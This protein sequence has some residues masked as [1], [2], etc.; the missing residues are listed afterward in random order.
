MENLAKDSGR[1]V[2]SDMNEMYKCLLMDFLNFDCSSRGTNGESHGLFS[3][4][5]SEPFARHFWPC[6][7]SSCWGTFLAIIQF[8]GY[9]RKKGKSLSCVRL[10]GLMDC[11]LPGSSIHG[12]SQAR[13]LEWGAIAISNINNQERGKKESPKP[14]W[15]HWWILLSTVKRTNINPFQILEEA[16]RRWS[17][18]K[19]ILQGIT[20]NITRQNKTIQEKKTIR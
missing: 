11:S 13:V 7:S 17:T 2:T 15:V 10:C 18:P 20:L 8:S 3:F 16:W 4:Q 1:T 14:D 5:M 6:Y 12:I 9:E 19:L